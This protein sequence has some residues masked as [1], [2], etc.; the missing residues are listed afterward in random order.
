MLA[1]IIAFVVI[2]TFSFGAGILLTIAIDTCKKSTDGFD[3]VMD[4]LSCSLLLML[5]IGLVVLTLKYT[6]NCL[7]IYVIA[8]VVGAFKTKYSKK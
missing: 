1:S 3:V 2:L 6:P 7:I 8:G 4:L 5:I